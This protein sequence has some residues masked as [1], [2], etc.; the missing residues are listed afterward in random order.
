[1]AIESIRARHP[2][3]AKFLSVLGIVLFLNMSENPEDLV[4]KGGLFGFET[5]EKSFKC[6][7][8]HFVTKI[9]RISLTV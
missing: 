2:F 9:T 3:H 7:F 8:S 4:R 5:P 6:D 1:M